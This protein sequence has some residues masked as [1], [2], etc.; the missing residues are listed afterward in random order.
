MCFRQKWMNQNKMDVDEREI[1][2]TSEI[3]WNDFYDDENNKYTETNIRSTR[4]INS[5]LIRIRKKQFKELLELGDVVTIDYFTVENNE[6]SKQR[7]ITSLIN[8][9]RPKIRDNKIRIES[10]NENKKIRKIN[11]EKE[12]SILNSLYTK[13]ESKR[14]TNYEKPKDYKIS[15]SIKV[16]D[17]I[18]NEEK[19]FKINKLENVVQNIKNIAKT[20][21]NYSISDRILLE[22]QLKESII[23]KPL[24][25][26]VKDKKQDSLTKTKIIIKAKRL[27]DVLMIEKG[28]MQEKI[29]G[30]F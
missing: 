25:N 21:I 6:L 24:T 9:E 30:K 17:D 28:K 10:L 4:K 7:S 16:S 1:T 11:E 19:T 15:I 26:A 22:K 13:L 20:I 14:K 18:K 23:Y 3:I 8:K 2:L 29:K 5:V 27:K 12:K